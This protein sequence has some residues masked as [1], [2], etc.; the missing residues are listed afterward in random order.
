MRTPWRRVLPLLGLLLFSCVTYQS[1]QR[2]PAS[3]RYFWWSSIPLDSTPLSKSE[4]TCEEGG[5][6]C[7]EWGP[8]SIVIESGLLARAL[9]FSAIPAFL[10][11]PLITV[12]LGRLGISEVL[13][14]MVSMPLL[15]GSWFYLLGWLIDRSERKRQTVAR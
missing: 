5:E 2:H 6:N 14:F 15:I 4:S 1:T 3:S 7:P 8:Q 9:I 12:E 10:L 13:T 11:G